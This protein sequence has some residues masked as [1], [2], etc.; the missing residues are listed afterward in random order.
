MYTA[1]TG[2]F[3]HQDMDKVSHFPCS[4]SK[5]KS[6]SSHWTVLWVTLHVR[7]RESNTAKRIWYNTI[8][9]REHTSVN[10]ALTKN[11]RGIWALKKCIIS[12]SSPYIFTS[13]SKRMDPFSTVILPEIRSKQGGVMK[14]L[15]NIPFT[16][17]LLK[18]HFCY[19][20]FLVAWDCRGS[21]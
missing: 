10:A 8:F 19:M 5:H 2:S 21:Y 17:R 13:E 14:L 16:K 3:Q 1:R 18:L 11:R 20:E 15:P 4:V 6:N 12:P 7:V 9:F